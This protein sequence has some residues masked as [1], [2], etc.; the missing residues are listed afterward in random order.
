MTD[1]DDDN[2]IQFNSIQFNSVFFGLEMASI[3][4]ELY[5]LSPNNFTRV[6]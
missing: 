1:S 5:C 6:R 4:L 3:I 2:S